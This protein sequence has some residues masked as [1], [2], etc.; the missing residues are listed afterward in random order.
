M[1]IKILHIIDVYLPETMIWLEKLLLL[2]NDLY[3]HHIH[4]DYLI[5][6]VNSNFT[7]A[8]PSQKAV[9]YPITIFDKISNKIKRIFSPNEVLNYIRLHQ[10]DLLHVHFGHL[11]LDYFDTIKNLKIPKVISF[12]GFDYERLPHLNPKIKSKYKA[13]G[14]LGCFFIVEGNYSR[15]V[16]HSYGIAKERIKIV[17]MLYAHQYDYAHKSLSRPIRF[18]QV[19]TY[20]EKKGQDIFLEAIQTV[21]EPNFIVDFYGEIANQEYYSKLQNL[22][23]K[24]KHV[25]VTLSFKD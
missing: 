15:N 9:A 20:T 11:A 12:Y 14:E 7:Q 24:S 4:T 10:I 19:A 16:L 22:A 1:K 3:E 25:Q 17:H 23:R 21:S 18:V 13:L 5:G 8:D 6:K 2:S